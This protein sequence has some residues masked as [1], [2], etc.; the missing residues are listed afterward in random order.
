MAAHKTTG[1][2]LIGIGIEFNLQGMLWAFVTGI[3]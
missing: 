3:C 1:I 2:R